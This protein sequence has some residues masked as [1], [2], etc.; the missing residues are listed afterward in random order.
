MRQ[1]DLHVHTTAS[2]GMMTPEAVVDL[3]RESGLAGIAVTDHDTVAGVERAQAAGEKW[4]FE[5]IAGVEVSTWANGQDI[6]ILGYFIDI[7]DEKLL[8]GLKEQQESRQRRNSMIIDRLR[9]MGVR[10][11]MEEVL[12][13]KQDVGPPT[14]V[15]RPHIAE[16]LVEKAI[17]NSM[18]EAFDRFLGKDGSAYVTTP[19]ISPEDAI[20]LIRDSGGVPVLAHPGLYEDDRLV[21]R[22]AE[23][24]LIGMEVRH[25]DHDEKM[26]RR[27]RDIAIH[28][29]LV[30]TAGS[31]FHG[32]R[33]GSMY[34]APLG[35]CTVEAGVIKQLV[36]KRIK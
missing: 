30:A 25:P 27:Y 2:D 28:Y 13:K 9:A 19:R 15:G 20:Q 1:W 11:S 21:R 8:S 14:N 17:V 16:V 6:H 26:E 12:A 24:G 18:D 4:G 23:Q 35:T 7:H 32:E 3:A 22:L 34:H 29:S 36:S 33:H 5:V 31:D 10:I